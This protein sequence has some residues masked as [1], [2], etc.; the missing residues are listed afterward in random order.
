MGIRG[1]ARA[2]QARYQAL[3]CNRTAS[4]IY[5][6]NR[7]PVGVTP[8][9]NAGITARYQA[10]TCNPTLS[11]TYGHNRRPKRGRKPCPKRW[12][13][14]QSKSGNHHRPKCWITPSPRCCITASPYTCIT[15]SSHVGI[16]PC[17]DVGITL[18]P[19]L[20]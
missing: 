7:R 17:P 13:D 11:Y 6:H 3:T 20:A 15:A 4:Y 19:V 16:T 2:R 14:C 10:L 5:G 9:P 1:F 18:T 8:A 12:H